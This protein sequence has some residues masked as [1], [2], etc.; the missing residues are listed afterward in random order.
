MVEIGKRLGVF[1]I[2]NLI[3]WGVFNGLENIKDGKTFC[4]RKRK[5]KNETYVDWKGNVYLGPNDGWV[6]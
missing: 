4:G 2:G 3:L 5:P 1:I 6:S